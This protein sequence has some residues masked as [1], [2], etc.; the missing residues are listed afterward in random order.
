MAETH[1]LAPKPKAA[2]VEK[3]G[4][5]RA[6]PSHQAF[7]ILHLG[8]TVAPIVAGA[9]KFMEKLTNWEMYL[10]PS[11]AR[12]SPFSA[13]GTMMAVG[14]IEILAGI[15]VA[16]RPRVGAYI[17]AGWLAGIM[18]NLCIMGSFWDIAL[19]DLGLCLGAL[20]LARL[21]VEHEDRL[22]RASLD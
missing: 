18:I 16:L 11:L 5:V 22:A 14:V 9:D 10:A 6:S 21:S 15:I 20:A 8:F 19:R 13:H 2:P 4:M 3:A 7:L 1:V 17:V 12:L